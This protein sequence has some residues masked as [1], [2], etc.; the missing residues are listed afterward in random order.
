MAN[1][2]LT[3]SEI[4][5]AIGMVT[6]YNRAPG[7]WEPEMLEDARAI[8][9]GGLRSFFH[10]LPSHQWRFLERRKVL[11]GE[12]TYDTGTVTIVDGTVTLATGTWPSWAG[13]GVLRIG[14]K[15][16][17]IQSRTSDSVV[18]LQVDSIDADAG[19]TYTLHRWRYAMPS[20]FG[21]II[22][23][24]V[25]NLGNESRPMQGG[26]E[27]ELRLRHA[28]N[29]QVGADCYRARYARFTE[30]NATTDTNDHYVGVWPIFDAEGFAQF[31]YRSE[32]LDK[33]DDSDLTAAGTTIQ[34]DATHAETLLSAIKA[35]AEQTYN[36]VTDGPFTQQFDK[37]LAAS[38]EHDRRSGGDERVDD[39]PVGVNPRLRAMFDPSYPSVYYDVS[40]NPL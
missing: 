33:L 31:T 30:T 20:D 15:T 2:N 12:T 37:R 9:R 39:S 28:M 14:D 27:G 38:I 13:D 36:R 21:E 11:S 7:Q 29:F 35:S 19:T 6:G 17:F 5:R 40:G 1:L 32:P 24:C 3:N 34:I 26:D 4:L 8:I 25:Y 18:V 16:L 23:G 22:G 10:P